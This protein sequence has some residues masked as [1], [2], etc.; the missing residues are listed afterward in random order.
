MRRRDFLQGMAASAASLEICDVSAATA[1]PAA[2]RSWRKTAV[3][4]SLEGYT[5]VIEFKRQADSWK[6]YE[7]LRTR[8]GSLAFV[9]SSGDARLLT[10][11]AEA[12]M[13]EGSPYLG[14]SLKDVGLSSPDLLADH[15][16]QDGDPDPEKVKSGAPPMASAEKNP[17][18][19]PLLWALRKLMT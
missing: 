9:S 14:L 18:M 13:P 16:L 15:L 2:R 10:K 8:E 4:G 19:G 5:P 7:D 17:R 1:L 11:S 3:A 6:V 12:S